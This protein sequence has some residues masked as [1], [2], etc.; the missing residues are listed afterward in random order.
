[1]PS[2]IIITLL[3]SVESFLFFLVHFNHGLDGARIAIRKARKEGVYG[4]RRGEKEREKEK[5]GMREKSFRNLNVF[6]F[7][8]KPNK[9]LIE[10]VLKVIII[11]I[12]IS[13]LLTNVVVVFKINLI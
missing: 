2:V 9:I 12:M 4:G 10:T 5:I 3:I 1:M 7:Y 13:H 6:F 8:S 11:I